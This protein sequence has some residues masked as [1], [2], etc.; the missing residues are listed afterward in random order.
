[1][2]LPASH[3]WARRRSIAAQSCAAVCL[4]AGLPVVS[5]AQGS[6]RAIRVVRRC[7]AGGVDQGKD[8]GGG[9]QG[10]V[11]RQWWGAAGADR[12]RPEA[13]RQPRRGGIVGGVYDGCLFCRR[14]RP[15]GLLPVGT[16]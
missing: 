11:V 4:G 9:K 16:V 8:R 5:L 3:Q 10:E 6:S 7:S 12:E 14:D 2:L 13:R 1:M 15:I